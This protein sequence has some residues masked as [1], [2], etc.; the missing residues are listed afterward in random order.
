M[1]KMPIQATK[2]SKR[3]L[4]KSLWLLLVL[5]I[6]V[7]VPGYILSARQFVEKH[8]AITQNQQDLHITTMRGEAA[9][10]VIDLGFSGSGDGA[11]ASPTGVRLILVGLSTPLQIVGPSQP[12][13]GDTYTISNKP[14]K[15]E[16]QGVVT[17]PTSL[18]GPM[19]RQLSGRITGTILTNGP[20]GNSSEDLT[21]P[22]Q[23]HLLPQESYFWS[24]G[25]A[26][27]YGFTALT[28]LLLIGWLVTNIWDWRHSRRRKSEQAGEKS[29]KGNRNLLVAMVVIPVLVA[30]L[31]IFGT[32]EGDPQI[33]TEGFPEISTS[34]WLLLALLAISLFLKGVVSLYR[35]KNASAK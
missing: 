10:I 23:I 28:Y 8:T 13:W 34:I 19:D 14:K 31:V 7:A 29:D 25:R 35:G 21:I 33:P 26:L 22:V 5:L 1:A 27:W 17:L 11:W 24:G 18:S 15:V 30:G 4:N 32:I 16:V 12:N 6:V 2:S 3:S 9:S 20:V